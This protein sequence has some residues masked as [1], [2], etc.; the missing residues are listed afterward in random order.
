MIIKKDFTSLPNEKSLNRLGLFLLIFFFLISTFVFL[1]FAQAQN[2]P[3]SGTLEKYNT[4]IS[5]VDKLIKT[6]PTEIFS[7]PF[8]KSARQPIALPLTVGNIGKEDPFTPPTPPEQAVFTPV[9]K[10]TR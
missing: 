5:R 1:I 2:I 4:S 8:L 6:F 10:T 3:S 7:A 9:K